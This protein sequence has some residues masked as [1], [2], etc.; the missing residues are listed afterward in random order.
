[1]KPQKPEI[2][3]LI[4]NILPLFTSQFDFPSPEDEKNT[5]IDEIPIRIGSSIKK[6]DVV[7]YHSGI[8]VFLIEAK[9]D[10]KPEK[11]AV[12]QALSYIRNYPVE[13]FSKN[14]FRPRFFAITIGKQVNFYAHRFEIEKNNFKDWA[15]KLGSPIIFTELLEKYGLKRIEK[16]EIFTPEIFRKEVLNELGPLYKFEERIT[17]DVVKNIAL[18]ILSFLQYGRDYTAHRPYIDIENYKD[19]QAQI[20]QVYEKFDW[21]NSLG[22]ETA[23]EFRSYILRS[24]QGTNLNQYLTEQCVIAFMINL[25]G[26]LL[27]DT[28]IL[29]FECGSGGFLAAVID[30]GVKLENIRGIDIDELPYIVAKTYLALYFRKTGVENIETLPIKK[31][32][33][34]FYHGDDYDLIIGNPAGGNIYEHGEEDKIISEGLINLTDK[35]HIFSEYELSIQQAVRSVKVNGKICLILP[36]GFFSN[37]KDEFLRKYIANNSKILAIISL[38]RGVFKKGTSTKQ[39]QKGSQTSSQK[40]SIL[41]VEKN[42]IIDQNNP[43]GEL[44]FSELEYQIFL[45]VIAEPETRKGA[46]EDWLEPELNVVWQQWQEWQGS[47]RLKDI[48]LIEISKKED[49]KPKSKKIS[50]R[51][52]EAIEKPK[53]SKPKSKTKISNSLEDLFK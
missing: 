24:F 52:I 29:D 50:G 39:Q 48:P 18:Q 28:K 16:K 7:Y 45:T 2:A 26:K 11:D 35:K 4:Q 8:P 40:M 42:K 51:I 25:I 49:V 43:I 3:Y 15:E 20:R 5:K 10:G 32:N 41:F 17:P 12:D 31:D 19:R 47:G 6:P 21:L 33:G 46:I 44:D 53:F 36:D 1:M 30:K 38:P 23:R 22:S 34:L 27:P 14:S 37:S 13:E 9:K